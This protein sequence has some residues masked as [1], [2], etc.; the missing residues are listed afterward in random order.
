MRNETRL[1]PMPGKETKSRRRR[2]GFLTG[3]GLWSLAFG[4]L[5]YFLPPLPAPGT[6]EEARRAAALMARAVAA[7]RERR[8]SSGPPIDPLSDINRTGLIG[9]EDTS[10][11]TSP[12]RLEAKRTTANPLVAGALVRMFREAGAGRGDV[13]AV[14]ASGSFPGLIL[15]TLCAA[16]A[17]GI[18]P[19]LIVSLGASRW[20][21]NDPGWTWL[22]MSDC[23]RRAGVLDVEPAALSL[24]GGRDGGGGLPE[25]GRVLL[26]KKI[27]ETGLPFIR[28]PDLPKNV[29]ARIA[30]FEQ[31]AGGRPIRVFVN[32]GGS[33][34]D[35]GTDGEVLKLR[36]GFNPAGEIFVPPPDRRGV[37]QEMARRGI[38]VIHL[39]FVQGL[40]ERYG[41]P[42]DPV[43]LPGAGDGGSRPALSRPAGIVLLSLYLAGVAFGL[44]RIARLGR[45][46]DD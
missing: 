42:W 20:G 32:I 46:L 2:A 31:S 8:E 27:E 3:L 23:L 9:R 6:D 21:A 5:F 12:G 24:G 25:N 28:E 15:A 18:E 1:E 13:A 17:R 40:A 35:M 37:V 11:T 45:R 26:E 33:F 41:L 22:E 10:I 44:F 19:R 16:A 4:A 30:L 34:A 29:A 43:P 36:P 38:P 14:G 39:L 7:L